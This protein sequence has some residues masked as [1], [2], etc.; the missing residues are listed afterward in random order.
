MGESPD[1]FEI[2][3]RSDFDEESES[4]D[5]SERPSKWSEDFEV[6][7]ELELGTRKADL[8]VFSRLRQF[9]AILFA[10][11][12]HADTGFEIV[13]PDQQFDEAQ[14]PE[15]RDRHDS[16]DRV[17][18]K[19]PRFIE[20]KVVDSRI[21][22][23]ENRVSSLP[24]PVYDR[25]WPDASTAQNQ[26]PDGGAPEARNRIYAE[27]IEEMI[28]NGHLENDEVII[29]DRTLDANR[30]S[31]IDI[32]VLPF[33]PFRWMA[34]RLTRRKIQGDIT[35]DFAVASKRKV[36]RV[37]KESPE[38]PGGAQFGKALADARSLSDTD[39]LKI[40]TSSIARK[41]SDTGIFD[42]KELPA[43]SVESADDDPVVSRNRKA[44][45]FFRT[46]TESSAGSAAAAY[47]FESS[48]NPSGSAEAPGS[49]VDEPLT[50]ANSLSGRLH[51]LLENSGYAGTKEDHDE[52]LEVG[53]PLESDAVSSAVRA[54]SA[55]SLV[56]RILF[57]F[58]TIPKRCMNAEGDLFE[59]RRLKIE[60]LLAAIPA[61]ATLTV[62]AFMISRNS[63]IDKFET[64]VSFLNESRRFD[65]AGETDAALIAAM[66]S[67]FENA[68]PDNRYNAARLFSKSKDRTEMA[69]GYRLIRYLASTAGGNQAD[70]H[71]FIAD[72]I[73]R[74]VEHDPN[75]NRNLFYRYLS[76][77][78]T[79][80]ER[81]PNRYD[82][83]ERL[84]EGLMLIGE[85]RSLSGLLIPTLEFWPHGHF[86]L[87]QVA[88]G[89][90]DD[91]LQKTHALAMVRHFRSTPAE[92]EADQKFRIRF[93]ISLALA[94][95]FSEAES[96]VRQLTVTPGNDDLHKSLTEKI[97]LIRIITRIN[98][99]PND[100]DQDIEVLGSL[101]EAED[102]SQ[103]FEAAVKRQL[104]RKGPL[105]PA[106]L[107]LCRNLFAT[108]KDTFDSDD[109]V[110]WASILRQNQQNDEAREFL[111]RA[112]KLS[113]ENDIA[114]NNL[115]NLLYK[116]EPV[117]LDR[118]LSLCE[119]VL[120]RNPKVPTFL[121]T[122][123]QVLAKLGRDEEAI[124]DLVKSLEAFP[125]VPEIHET[126]AR[127][128]R[129][130]GNAELADAHQKRFE[131]LK[132]R[133]ESQV[134]KAPGT[135]ES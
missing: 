98:E 28:D 67:C 31:W 18:P 101:L 125:N 47:E 133:P 45:P 32:L 2:V 25:G 44:S 118:A 91:E 75:S 56:S 70:A 134:S 82:L 36:L 105:R 72:E 81:S 97:D 123:G 30:L 79:G 113:P 87:A 35:D 109:Y 4:A 57:W 124:A 80:F 78:R 94:G 62:M 34:T 71:L 84:A 96:F 106:L 63:D 49:H 107:K 22:R 50:Q 26:E 127:C 128:Y 27:R 10:K 73:L 21:E 42:S 114:S 88:F 65:K 6:G 20:T 58:L 46:K 19:P 41:V 74:Q 66:R 108:R 129:K 76:E 68:T 55:R 85:D 12:G 29:A 86:Y 54:R 13:D 77:L 111:D 112:V 115:A 95:E 121:E 100:S 23:G 83:L 33:A 17:T 60:P 131:E 64:Y 53:V 7:T 120:K 103:S 117:D 16:S 126:L 8:A 39:E 122:R 59:Q 11:P 15:I 52:P 135:D 9:F 132:S 3:D 51:E 37:R 40:G 93:A 61:V 116:L 69:R 1:D 48:G 110:F 119:S 14:S 99:F 89:K 43:D 130:I 102:L 24:S 38:T 92:L 5:D 90:G 104:L